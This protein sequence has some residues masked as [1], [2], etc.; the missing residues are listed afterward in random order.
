MTLEEELKNIAESA[1]F[2]VTDN[3]DKIVRAKKLLFKE[4]EQ[5]LRCPCASK[6][7]T[8]YCISEAC[9]FDILEDGRCHCNLFKRQEQ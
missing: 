1:Q 3:F 2:Q 7:E 8:R 4:R 5:Q 9:M 6:D